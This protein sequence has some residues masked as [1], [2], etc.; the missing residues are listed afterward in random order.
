M[1]IQLSS[2]LR[3]K[4][5]TSTGMKTA[6]A[7]GVM[8]IYSGTQPVNADAAVSGTLLL[9]VT[10]SSGAFVFGTSTNGINLATSSLGVIAKEV[11]EVWSGV[12]IAAGTAGWFRLMGNPSDA[13]GSS[14]TL[15]R[16]DG[17]VGTGGADLNVGS[18]AVAIGTPLTIDV[19][20]FTLPAA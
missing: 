4:M 12:G 19:F 15:A 13:L 11:A 2:G 17:S 18:T 14:T 20:Q 5:L 9:K 10:L 8:Y 16:L 3:D 6:F 1:T 7:N